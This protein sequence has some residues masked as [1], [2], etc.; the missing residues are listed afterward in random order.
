M[1]FPFVLLKLTCLAG[2]RAVCAGV[3]LWGCPPH[4]PAK[5]GGARA[6]AGHALPQQHRPAGEPHPRD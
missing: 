3:V 4:R 6:E 1:I 2:Q 5:A